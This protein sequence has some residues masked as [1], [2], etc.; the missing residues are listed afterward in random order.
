MHTKEEKKIT[1]IVDGRN[2]MVFHGVI[3]DN[4]RH[5]IH[6]LRLHMSALWMMLPLNI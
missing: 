6:E 4:M 5:R 3:S 2:F 1:T